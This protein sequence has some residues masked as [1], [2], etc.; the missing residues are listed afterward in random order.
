M[1]Q[2]LSRY[3]LCAPARPPRD[4]NIY[5]DYNGDEGIFINYWL[6]VFQEFEKLSCQESLTFYVVWDYSLVRDLPSYGKD[7]VAVLITDEERVI[8]HYLRKVRFVFKTYGFRPWCGASLR[9]QSHVAIAKCVR[10][11]AT[12]TSHFASFVRESGV[13]FERAGGMVVPLGYAQQ[14]DVPVKP[15]ETRRYLA[16]FLGSVESK[17]RARFSLHALMGTPKSIARTRMIDSLQKLRA[18]EPDRIFFGTTKSFGESIKTGGE[19][20]SEIMADTK[21]CLAPRGSSVETYRFFEAMRVGCVVI[22]DRL[23]PH[24]FYVGCPA[25]QIDDWRDLE[26]VM[27]TLLATPGRLMEIHRQT[28]AWWDMKLS[29]PAVAAVISRC[30]ETRAGSQWSGLTAMPIIWRGN[31]GSVF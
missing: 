14:T 7:V 25:V 17:D 10:E 31:D 4:L 1:T 9:G 5:D 15:F 13:S 16:G 27:R 29:E 3:V 24:W 11:W 12:W 28:L 21:I 20:Y 22:C 18:A 19:R 2:S 6:R 30:L 23:P 8:P 26:A